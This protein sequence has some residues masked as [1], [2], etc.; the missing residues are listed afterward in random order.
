MEMHRMPVAS[1]VVV[2]GI[3][4]TYSLVAVTFGCFFALFFRHPHFFTN[5]MSHAGVVSC[6]V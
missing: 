4:L 5:F 6:N 3:L 1:L 2:I